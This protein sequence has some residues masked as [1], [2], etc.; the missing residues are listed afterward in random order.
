[1]KTNH[2]VNNI[3]N[4]KKILL[5]DGGE[6]MNDGLHE[7]FGSEYKVIKA[8]TGFNGLE[9]AKREKPDMIFCSAVMPD[10]DGYGISDILGKDKDTMDIP[11]VI[12]NNPSN[13]NKALKESVQIAGTI[14]RLAAKKNGKQDGMYSKLEGLLQL[15]N[16]ATKTP[17]EIINDYRTRVFDKKENIYY[18]GDVPNTV[19]MIKSGRVKTVKMGPGGKEFIIDIYEKGS[20]FGHMAIFESTEYPDTAIALEQTEVLLI[21][22]DDFSALVKNNNEMAGRLIKMLADDISEKEE[23]LMT[24]AYNSVRARV[25]GALLQLRKKYKKD[26]S[27]VPLT[28]H[29][30]RDDLAGLI[31]TTTESLIRTLT[32]FKQEGHIETNKGEITILDTAGLERIRRLS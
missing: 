23:R 18:E 10:I 13:G 14:E 24:L 32:D 31:G 7:M 8:A 15:I 28:I 3:Q 2:N 30:S 25:A 4:M 9:M 5:I 16:G 6:N 19:Y 20:F 1:M 21:P 27:S 29:V 26:K 22:K 17:E 11:F 12:M